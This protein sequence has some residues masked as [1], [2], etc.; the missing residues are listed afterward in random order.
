MPF[1]S[2]Q[3]EKNDYITYFQTTPY[4]G[5]AHHFGH[6]IEYPVEGDTGLAIRIKL[7]GAKESFLTLLHKVKSGHIRKD[8]AFGS[9]DYLRGNRKY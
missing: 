6:V 1:E 3:L 2:K 7:L 4:N 8:N 9:Y 5:I